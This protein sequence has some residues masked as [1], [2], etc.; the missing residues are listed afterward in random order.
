MTSQFCNDRI[1]QRACPWAPGAAWAVHDE[2]DAP[3][4][5][6][7]RTKRELRRIKPTVSPELVSSRFEPSSTDCF[8]SRHNLKYKA[9]DISASGM[10]WPFP[11][12]SPPLVRFIDLE[13]GL[14]EIQ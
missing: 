3:P 9:A 14:Y 7:C 6:A 10:P 2:L 8:L 12:Q 11:R 5:E 13:G 4:M 1:R